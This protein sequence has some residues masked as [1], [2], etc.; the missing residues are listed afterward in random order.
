SLRSHNMFLHRDK[1]STFI[2]SVSL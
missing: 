2:L 1:F